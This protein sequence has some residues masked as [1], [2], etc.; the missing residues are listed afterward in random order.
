MTYSTKTMQLVHNGVRL[1]PT[2]H[3][4]MKFQHNTLNALECDNK[5]RAY[6]QKHGQEPLVR[7]DN[8]EAKYQAM[9]H[10]R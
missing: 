10:N 4:W 3:V 2:V 7:G 1:L 8:Q 6:N 5:P 9:M